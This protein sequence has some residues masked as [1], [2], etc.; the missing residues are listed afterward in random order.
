MKTLHV[1]VADKIATYQ[2]R[3]G[4]I[5]CGNSDYQVKFAFDS[6]WDAHS[7][8]TARFIRDGGAY[9]DK[10]FTGNVCPV[11]ILKNTI[12]V[13][14][15]VFAGNLSTTTPAV[16]G[17]RKSILCDEGVPEDPPED[18]YTQLLEKIDEATANGGSS[19]SMSVEGETLKIWR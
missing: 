4:E 10:V 6:E 8:K 11:P 17:C 9:E 2:K 7:L 14:V 18:V 1:I 13:S 3:D 5:V 16:I 15:G 12:S 19:F